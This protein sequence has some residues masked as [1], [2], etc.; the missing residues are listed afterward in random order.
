MFHKVSD[1]GEEGVG[2]RRAAEIGEIFG[3]RSP[4][5]ARRPCG[6]HALSSSAEVSPE[7]VHAELG[8]QKDE[9]QSRNRKY[10]PGRNHFPHP[11][12][13]PVQVSRSVKSLM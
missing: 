10:N 5:R 3:L 12:P 1:P 6:Q 13:R 11:F 9:V 2:D 7:H 4:G 8:Q